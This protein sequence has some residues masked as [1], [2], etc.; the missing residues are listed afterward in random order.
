MPEAQVRL[1]PPPAVMLKVVNPL[2]RRLLPSRVGGWMGDLTLLEFT[3]RRTGRRISTPVSVHRVD[4]MLFTT[5][6]RPWRL[7][8]T[9]GAPVTLTS[10]GHA[11]AGSAT[12]LDMTPEEVGALIKRLLD[13]GRAPRRLGIQ[14]PRGHT[15]TAD[16]LAALGLSVIRYDVGGSAA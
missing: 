14:I 8:F 15:P 12:L 11:V 6:E 4:D 13:S 5:T 9:G 2:L 1:A 10:R 7:N 16:E 3:G